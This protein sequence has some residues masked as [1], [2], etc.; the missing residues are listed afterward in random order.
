MLK[1][2]TTDEME[3]ASELCLSAALTYPVP[4]LLEITQQL[5]DYVLFNVTSQSRTSSKLL[6]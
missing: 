3:I 2:W 5:V 4:C 1:S 6:V